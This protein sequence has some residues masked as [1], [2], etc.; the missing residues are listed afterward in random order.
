MAPKK[1]EEEPPKILLG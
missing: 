1:K